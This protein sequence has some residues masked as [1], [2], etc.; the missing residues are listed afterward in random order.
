MQ[1]VERRL[2]GANN[3]MHCQDE[4][5]MNRDQEALFIAISWSLDRVFWPGNRNRRE[6]VVPKGGATMKKRV[7]AVAG[8]LIGAALIWGSTLGA[9]AHGPG[10]GSAHPSS[11]L[12][13][14]R[15]GVQQVAERLGIDEQHAAPGTID[16]GKELLP[17][18][19]ITLQ[20]AVQ[21]AQAAVSGQLGEVDLEHDHGTLVF[22]VD[23]GDHDVKVDAATG[24]VLG[25]GAD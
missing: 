13:S 7:G 19:K 3:T 21:T 24:A 18:A 22:N 17:Q 25:S 11:L 2:T 12:S 14:A 20:Q 16:D 8:L 6:V 23:I 15:S 1:S 9:S 4:M 10:A 5:T